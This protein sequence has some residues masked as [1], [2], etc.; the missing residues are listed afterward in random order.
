MKKEF[1]AGLA[2]GVF[3]MGMAGMAQALSMTDVGQIDQFI[4]G[5]ELASSGDAT[6]LAWVEQELNGDYTMVFKNDTS[7]GSGW[8]LVD[9]TTD[10][11]AYLMPEDAEYF[12][13]KTGELDSTSCEHFL[14]K[15]LDKDDYA[16]IQLSTNGGYSIKNSG[17]LSHINGY[18]GNQPIPEPATM[19]LMGTGL[20]G[21]AATRRRKANKN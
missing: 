13:I 3:F 16:V 9:N 11:Y 18:N 6:E 15:N 12:L 7:N 10:V 21:L 5:A 19:L 1:L 2:T 4:V 8:V 14:Y 17:K 20:A